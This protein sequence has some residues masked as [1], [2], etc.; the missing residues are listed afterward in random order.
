M[1]ALW[2]DTSTR[3]DVLPS[4]RHTDPALAP[5]GHLSVL[6]VEDN[7]GDARLIGEAFAE[8]IRGFDVSYADSLSV[9][10]D[11]LGSDHPDVVLLDLGLP[12]SQ[13][14]DTMRAIR[15]R[16]PDVPVV[17]LTGLSDERTGSEAVAAGAQDYFV[18]G[19][20]HPHALERAIVY[21]VHRQH[22]LQALDAARAEEVRRHEQFLSN[23][24]ARATVTPHRHPS[25][26]NDPP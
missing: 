4:D 17:V 20:V 5:M 2:V 1:G 9:A 26:R 18:K 23:G 14:L 19:D 25:V 3:A 8:T 12:D 16:A 13:G 24:L 10:C 7:R 22:I 6:V 15:H 11:R 21:A